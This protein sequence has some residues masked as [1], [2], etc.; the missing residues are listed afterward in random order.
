MDGGLSLRSSPGGEAQA[1]K[2]WGESGGRVK[3]EG[4]AAAV[5]DTF[6]CWESEWDQDSWRQ[7][8]G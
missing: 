8:G 7:P 4:L 5:Q 3:T 1:Q 6:K 2:P